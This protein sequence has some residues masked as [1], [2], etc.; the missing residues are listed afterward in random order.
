MAAAVE[1]GVERLT[2]DVSWTAQTAEGAAQSIIALCALGI[3]PSDE[4]V[5]GMFVYRL[6]DGS[7]C[8]TAGGGKNQMS[9]EQALC[10]L[11]ALSRLAEG[12]PALY[13]MSDVRQTV[14][15]DQ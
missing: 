12:K 6:P 4:L 5:N 14:S 10:A 3:R 1:R 11:T 7:Y 13:E 8:H 15:P 2:R 9:T